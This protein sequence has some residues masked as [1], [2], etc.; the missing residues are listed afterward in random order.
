MPAPKPRTGPSSG[1]SPDG[2]RPQTF[3]ERLACLEQV[4]E[5][6]EGEDLPLEASLRR[7]REGVEHLRACRALLD[8]AEKR[9]AELVA[10]TGADGQTRVVEK[11]LRVTEKGLER[12]RE[13]PPRASASRAAPDDDLPF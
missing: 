7:Y 1:G 6:L 2:D 9:L 4:V 11:P 5:D 13:E 10:E 12:D 3:E 8:E